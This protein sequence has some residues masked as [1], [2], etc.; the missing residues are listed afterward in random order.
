MSRRQINILQRLPTVILKNCETLNHLKALISEY[1]KRKQFQLGNQQ[2]IH[3]HIIPIF[4][5][6]YKRPAN[7]VLARRDKCNVMVFEI[8]SLL[9]GTVIQPR[10]S[11]DP[12]SLNKTKLFC[13]WNALICL[14]SN[15][16]K[17][18]FLSNKIL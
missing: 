1:H 11:T 9:C 7:S 15:Y 5:Y 3:V 18:N 10:K 13:H 16:R 8:G 2:Q 6:N 17:D 14:H 4:R 12:E